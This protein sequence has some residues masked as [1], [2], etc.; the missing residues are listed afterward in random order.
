MNQLFFSEFNSSF[1][2]H[3]FRLVSFL[4]VTLIH[5][6]ICG[7]LYWSIHAREEVVILRYNAYL[8]INL[9]GVWWQLFVIPALSYFFVLVNFL[10]SE[11]LRRGGHSK[12]AFLLICGNWLITSASVIAAM[13]LSFINV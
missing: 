6:V 5:I 2:L 3:H 11:L 12:L 13:A 8:G 10:L 7:F 4:A 9:L 1:W